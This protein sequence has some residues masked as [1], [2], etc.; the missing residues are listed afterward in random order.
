MNM[1]GKTALDGLVNTDVGR[2]HYD[3]IAFIGNTGPD[4]A[5]SYGEERNRCELSPCGT[6][7]FIG[8]GGPMGQMH[9]QRAIELPDGPTTVIATEVSDQRLYAIK[10]RFAP[11]AEKNG[12]TLLTYNSQSS[13]KSLYDF[14]MEVTEGKGADD[15]VVSVPIAEVMAEGDT[16][17]NENGMLVFFAG[18]PNGTMAPM[19]LSNVY[20]NNSQYTGTS[21]LTLDDQRQVLDQA[22]KGSLSPGRSVGAIGGM[23]VTKEGIQ[24]VSNGEYAGKIVIF[25]Q[26]DDLPLIGL[27]ELKDVLPEVAEKLEPGTIWTQEAE[28][29]LFEKYWKG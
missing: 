29:A 16:L 25:P 7:V 20:L 10:E 8:A 17:M 23:Q 2:L 4:I 24:A 18:V 3:Y 15:V 21:G 12:R 22:F 11:L 9:V 13:H 1:V 14:V 26:I 6:T 19:N 28:E 5:A 27:D